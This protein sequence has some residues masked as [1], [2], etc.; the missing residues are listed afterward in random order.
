M[1][2]PEEVFAGVRSPTSVLE[3]E[4]PCQEPMKNTWLARHH[5][6]QRVSLQR[7]SAD[8]LSRSSPW[9][10]IELQEGATTASTPSVRPGSRSGSCRRPGSAGN[11]IDDRERAQR[12]TERAS[13]ER[14]K[15]RDEYA[16]VVKESA[17]LEEAQKRRSRR[18]ARTTSS[19]RR[20]L[21]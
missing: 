6:A 14:A 10:Q 7:H 4:R 9:K 5:N 3:F 18:E 8:R 16:K 11:R 17:R 15:I 21:N 19:R 12:V 20:A 2:R 1:A 13:A